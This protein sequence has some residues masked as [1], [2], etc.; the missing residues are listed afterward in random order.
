MSENQLRK[1]VQSLAEEKAPAEKI[2]LWPAIKTQIINNE[3]TT[4]VNRWP[5][6]RLVGAALGLALLLSGV[7]FLLTPQ[8]QAWAQ[9][10]FQFFNQAESD[11]MPYDAYHATQ[12]GSSSTLTPEEETAPTPIREDALASLMTMD[13]VRIAAGF[14]PYQPTWL[15]DGYQFA[16]A[17]YDDETKVIT[18]IYAYLGNQNNSFILRQ[19][20][21]AS[22]T[23]YDMSFIVGSSAEIQEVWVSGLYGEYVE[24]TWAGREDDI[25]WENDTYRRRMIWKDDGR[26][27]EIMY[28]GFPHYLL[29]DDMIAVAESLSANLP[30]S[31]LYDYLT[32]DEVQVRV[33]FPIVQPTSLPDGFEFDH[34][35]Y[36]Q[37]NDVVTLMYYYGG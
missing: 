22:L 13:E 11:Q 37:D 9:D 24:G 12:T 8:G 15:P 34:A 31:Y 6:L 23:E 32:L 27:F 20:S 10:T 21:Y 17:L 7:V 28:T 33:D 25:A 36:D 5:W 18:L 30:E 14:T 26:A 1:K 29:K 16:G 19:G 2:D 3:R 35:L 4:K